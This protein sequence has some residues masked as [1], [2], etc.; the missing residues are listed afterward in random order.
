[1]IEDLR[2]LI[3]TVSDQDRPLMFVGSELGSMIARFYTQL[4][5]K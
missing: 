3:T 5:S 2:R 4:Y 1:M